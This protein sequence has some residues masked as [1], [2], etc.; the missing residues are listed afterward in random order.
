MIYSYNDLQE[1][2]NDRVDYIETYTSYIGTNINDISVKN[3]NVLK[4]NIF[5]MLYNLSECIVK[6]TILLLHEQILSES[7]KFLDLNGAIKSTYI[8]FL[9]CKDGFNNIKDDQKLNLRN[10]YCTRLEFHNNFI[11]DFSYA[12]FTKYRKG[13]ISGNIDHRAIVKLGNLYGIEEVK[14]NREEVELLRIKTIRNDLAHGSLS[15]K[16]CSRDILFSKIVEL[17]DSILDYFILYMENTRDYFSNKKFMS[18]SI[19]VPI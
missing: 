15:Y 8:D 2:F 13:L 17:K 11:T 5:L 19:L 6:S 1:I 7:L 12:E 16:E 4:S 18:T 14:R 9:I 3:S 10:L